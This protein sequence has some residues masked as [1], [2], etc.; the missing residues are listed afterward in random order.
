[1]YNDPRLEREKSPG[2]EK[3]EPAPAPTDRRG[4]RLERRRGADRR[5]GNNQSYTGASRRDTIDRREALAERREDLTEST[6]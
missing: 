2:L 6:A 1:M 3:H 5:R 4:A